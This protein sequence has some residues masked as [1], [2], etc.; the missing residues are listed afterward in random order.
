[1]AEEISADTTD[2]VANDG[3]RGRSG[4]GTI[5]TVL[6]IEAIIVAGAVALW[7]IFTTEP[8]AQ[9]GGATRE[10]AMLVDV[11]EVSRIDQRPTFVATGTVRPSREVILRP[12]VEGKV[13][14]HAGALQPGGT[15]EAGD[16]LIT[17]DPADYR[18][19]VQQ[20]RSALA[21]AEAALKREKGQQRVAEREYELADQEL[22]GA[23][24]ALALRE[25]Q[26]ES[27]QA[28]VASAR[29]ALSQA[30][31]N[32]ERTTIEAPFDA[33][34]LDRR[35]DVGSQV[36]VGDALARLVGIETYWVEVTVPVSKLPWLAFPDGGEDGAP[37]GIHN[38]GAW[39][40]DARR[41]GRVFRLVG[42]LDDATRMA[43]VLVAVDD[44]LARQREGNPR[45]ILGTFV[46][47]H[48]EGRSLENVVALD[49][50]YLRSDDT[51]WVMGEDGK[52]DI[53]DVTIAVSDQNHAYIRDGLDDGER[54]V[55]SSLATIQ[56][57]APLRLGSDSSG[58][59]DD[60]S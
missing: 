20:R 1:M 16:D 58:S 18:Q 19:T 22:D 10:T 42:N 17:L 52:L 54:V 50:E 56:E 35:V 34:I 37:V 9:R 46:E 25:P 23:S 8:E 24:K 13:M 15:A 12:R 26:L 30:R 11:T 4:P 7:F 32:L 55:T 39:P 2:A 49:R 40:A 38:D 28:E 47:A 41:R 6:V 31:L 29:A 53:R 57:G 36:S 43:R 5:I 51:V 44:P 60:G 21:Q 45:L 14:D 27:A 33:Q 59:G 3:K 48:I